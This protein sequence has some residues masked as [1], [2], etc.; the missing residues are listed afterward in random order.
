MNKVYFLIFTWCI[1]I[2]A[3]AQQK[4]VFVNTDITHFWEAYDKIISTK[5]TLQQITYIE[6]LYLTKASPGLKSMIEVRNYTAKE[7]VNAIQQYP[8]FWKSIRKNTLSAKQH[9]AKIEKD[10]NGLKALYPAMKPSTIYFVMG[11]FRSGGTIKGD[12]VL[13]GAE[14]SLADKN[15]VINELPL[16]RQPFYKENPLVDALPLLCAHEYVHTQ[17]KPIVENLLSM[18]LYE[19]VAEFISC[20]ATGKKSDAPAIE[21]GKA[22]EKAVVAQFVK[23]LFLMAN[24]YN[25]LYG[26]NRNEFKV[27]DLGYYIGYEMA[28]RYYNLSSN[29]EKAI[30]ELIELNYEN[31][32]EVERIIDATQFLP[33]TLV[34]LYAD[35]DKERPTVVALSPFQNNSNNVEP[36]LTKITIT[37]SEP[38][39]GVTTS[40]D[41]GPL[42]EQAFPKI[43]PERIWSADAKTWTIEADL[44][45]G[46]HYQ[47]LI[48]NNFRKTNGVRLKPYL[49]DFSTK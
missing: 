39:N 43:K 36:G 46:T 25:W 4:Q 32:S 44:K 37:F 13:I 40:I 12:Q 23:D 19:G 11:V 9:Y 22:N 41:Y 16:W 49:I 31:E 33:K 28:E 7:Y 6:E 10:I 38:L 42:G 17:Q 1:G 2:S 34:A 20:K 45:P 21:F 47:I 30:Q 48:S 35:Y 29:K 14:A 3:Y 27:R 15:T 26:Q 24:D 8:E 5:D 18:C